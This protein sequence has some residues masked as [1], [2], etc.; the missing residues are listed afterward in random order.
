MRARDRQWNWLGNILRLGQ[1]RVVRQVL[2]NC[3]RS[4]PDSLFGNVPDLDLEKATEIAYDRD[5]W[6][7]MEHHGSANLYSTWGNA[8]NRHSTA[9]TCSRYDTRKQGLHL[10]LYF[11]SNTVGLL[12]TSQERSDYSEFP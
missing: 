11:R 3:V 5:K 9:G 4:T 2:L 1:H 10:H 6:K 12:V 7:A 8:V